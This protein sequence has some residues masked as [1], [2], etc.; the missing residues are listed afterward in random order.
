LGGAI[1]PDAMKFD[2]TLAVVLAFLVPGALLLWTLAPSVTANVVPVLDKSTTTTALAALLC[3]TFVVGVIIDSLRTVSV[4]PLVTRLARLFD[5]KGLP[6]TY[7][8]HITP[9]RLPVFEMLVS[10][11]YEY[12][13][14]NCNLTVS[15]IAS[16]AASALTS[17]SRTRLLL[18]F[19][20]LVFALLVSVR[21][22]IDSDAAL[23]QF[24]ASK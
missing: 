1:K 6:S 24:V 15:L 7:I 17:A 4:Q 13:R 19:A 9:E 10:R 23:R 22:R 8:S 20:A 14:L 11:S 16:I 12:Y 21:S 18:L 2:L 5:K 3:E